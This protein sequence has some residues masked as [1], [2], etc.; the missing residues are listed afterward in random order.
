VAPGTR[1]TPTAIQIENLGSTNIS[2]VWFNASYPG[3]LPYGTS[4]FSLHDA[5]NYVVVRRNQSGA[6]WFHP[7]L[8]EYNES[9]LIYL[10]LPAGATTHGRFR[11][12]ESE[13]FWVLKNDS[14]GGNCTNATFYMG[15]EPHNSTQSGTIDLSSCALTLTQTGTS[16]CR[17][18]ELTKYNSSWGYTDIMVGRDGGANVGLNYSM[19]VRNDCQQVY[20]YKWNE[21]LATSGSTNNDLDFD[22]STIYPG[23]NLI[24][25]VNVHVPYGIPSGTKTGALT[26]FVQALTA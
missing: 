16:G 9:T 19:M 6:E 18:G 25:N 2:R 14:S 26:V 15:V 1:G 21:D 10:T 12:A 11:S 20:F 5:G 8:V 22:N 4:D 7:N 23:G 17:T 3:S 24:A 13:Y